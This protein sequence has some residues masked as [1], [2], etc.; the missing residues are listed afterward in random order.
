MNL[1]L[2]ELETISH[3]FNQGGIMKSLDQQML[4]QA[5]IIMG[6][7]FKPRETRERRIYDDRGAYADLAT[8]LDDH[9]IKEDRRKPR[10]ILD[11]NNH[12][13]RSVLAAGQCCCEQQGDENEP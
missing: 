13:A 9:Q 7:L 4:N 2:W 3:Q 12:D 6:E 10:N 8:W 1:D 5:D 11:D